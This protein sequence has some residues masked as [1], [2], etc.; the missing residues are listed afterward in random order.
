MAK[1]WAVAPDG[2]FVSENGGIEL[3]IGII[4]GGG[5]E[6]GRDKGRQKARIEVV[7]KYGGVKV[8]VVGSFLLSDLPKA[9][10]SQIEVDENRQIDLKVETKS[11]D[12]MIMM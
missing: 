9:H 4:D 10:Y 6:W 1:E 8:D 7:S 11:G 2:R 3:G 12:V 5:T